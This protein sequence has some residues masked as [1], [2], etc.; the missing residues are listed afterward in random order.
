MASALSLDQYLTPL[1]DGNRIRCREV[2]GDFCQRIEDPVRLYHEVLWPVMEQVEKLFRSDRI[3]AASEHMATRINRS[4]ADQLQ[5]KLTRRPA[6]NKRLVIS[7][8]DAE[9]EELGAQML[10]DMFESRG[11]DVN[12]LGGGVPNDEILSLLGDVRPELLLIYGT[13]PTGVPPVKNTQCLTDEDFVPESRRQCYHVQS[14]R[15][16]ADIHLLIRGSH[17]VFP[18]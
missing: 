7:C 6:I 18:G 16:R 14:P 5:M 17:P 9:P 13:L 11:W 1:L 12:F 10:A 15:Y 8:A 3:N 2:M 4:I